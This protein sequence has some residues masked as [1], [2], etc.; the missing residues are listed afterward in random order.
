GVDRAGRV[1]RVAV[2]DAV[3]GAAYEGDLRLLGVGGD[4][5]V[6]GGRHVD[7]EEAAAGDPVERVAL[8][9]DVAEAPALVVGAD[10]KQ[11]QIAFVGS[12]LYGIANGN[13]GD[14]AG[15]IYSIDPATGAFVAGL[16]RVHTAGGAFLAINDAATMNPVPEPA[17]L[18]ALGLGALG[19]LR[20]RRKVA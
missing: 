9:R 10:A 19:V 8:R 5:L 2:G 13:A 20:R 7:R 12:A 18:A 4:R 3:E 15:T 14:P 1:A 11:T 16:N 6:G 17:S